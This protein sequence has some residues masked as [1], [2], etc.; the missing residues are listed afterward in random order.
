MG[1]PFGQL[2]S[3]V[4]AVSSQLLVHPQPTH[5]LGGVRSRKVLDAVLALLSSN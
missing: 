1:H 2:G 5:W 3:A 4:P